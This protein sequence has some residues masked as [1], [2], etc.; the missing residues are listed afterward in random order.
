MT[1]SAAGQ[2][3]LPVPRSEEDAFKETNL[4]LPEYPASAS[5]LQFPTQWTTNAIYVDQKTLAVSAD[6][7]VRFAL[8]VR[9]PSGAESVSFEGVRCATGERRVFAYGRKAGEGGAWS[10]ARNA[11][12][13]PIKDAG[14]NRYYFELWR[15]VFC[16]NNRTEVRGEIL[17]NLRRGGRE[18]LQSMPSE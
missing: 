5:L 17:K 9:S 7:A 12:W 4:V 3:N 10:V 1:A 8:V 16:D 14:I 13:R 15:D 6:G 11:E 2:S 18:R